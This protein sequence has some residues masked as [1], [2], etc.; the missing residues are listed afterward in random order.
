M[1]S[2]SP[3]FTQTIAIE[4]SPDGIGADVVG[5]DLRAGVDPQQLPDILAA[6]SEHLV[7]RF[8]G[9]RDLSLDKL[10]E[11]SS[12][13]GKLD[14]APIASVSMGADHQRP[15]PDITVISNIVEQGRALGGLGAYEAAWH[16]DMTYNVRPPK[17]SALY[18]VEVPPQGGNTQFANMVAAFETL[19]PELKTM[20]LALECIHDAS[21]NSAGELRFGFEEITDPRRTVG[22]RHPVVRTHPVTGR[23]SL[24][25]GRRRNAYLFGLPLDESEEL[26]DRLW[27]HATQ[28]S[29]VWTQ[30]WEVGDVVLWDN[31][32]TMHRRDAFDPAS[33]RLMYRTQIAGEDVR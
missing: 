6:W 16:A 11:F 17:G 8:R 25:L 30:R 1:S 2:R 15:R 22:A 20:A 14:A 33:R 32:C 19:P 3:F 23:K 27:A 13:F 9:N 29:P 21:R 4:P 10:A 24:F 12:L 5:V 28:R 31:R 26:L 18:A 7:L